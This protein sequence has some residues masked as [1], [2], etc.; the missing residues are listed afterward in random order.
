MCNW[1]PIK[2]GWLYGIA[3][4]HYSQDAPHRL[5]LTT[6]DAI[7]I[8]GETENWYFGYKKDDRHQQGIFPK[9]Y[10]VIVDAIRSSDGWKIRRSPIVEEITTILIEWQSHLLTY[11]LSDKQKFMKIQEKMLNLIKLRQQLLSGNLPTDEF[12]ELK[13]KATEQI[14]TGN[15]MLSLDMVVRDDAGNIIDFGLISTTQLY[16]LHCKAVERIKQS[17]TNGANGGTSTT[18]RNRSS[19]NYQSISH[20]FLVTL[21]SVQCKFVD[22]MEL[23][24]TLYA[25]ES[26][27]GNQTPQIYQLTE[28]YFVPW[29]KG[30]TYKDK[31]MLFTDLSTEDMNRSKIF[32]VAFMV[33]MGAMEARDPDAQ[34]PKG[35]KGLFEAPRRESSTS[36]QSLV[37]DQ[38]RRPFGVAILD[39]TPIKDNPHTFNDCAEMSIHTNEKEC[40]ESFLKR[41]LLNRDQLSSDGRS[42]SVSVEKVDGDI[43]QIKDDYSHI[44]R[45][46]TFARKMGFPEVIL[47]G[48]VRND[49]YL[50]LMG[51]DLG[52][53]LKSLWTDNNI[54]ICVSVCTDKGEIVPN[55]ISKGG[56]ASLENEYKSVIYTKDDRPKWNETIKIVLPIENFKHC[57]VK[58]LFKNRHS[59]EAKDKANK[60]FALAHVK[61]MDADETAIQQGEHSLAVY[62]ID[63]KADIGSMLHNYIDLPTENSQAN[64]LPEK[65]SAPGFAFMPKDSFIVKTNL[66]ST[67]LTQ[68]AQLLSLLNWQSNPSQLVHSLENL[69]QVQP[70]EMVKFYQ[71]ILDT[72]FNIFCEYPEHEKLVFKCIIRLIDIVSNPKYRLFESVLDVYIKEG[73]SATLAYRKLIDIVR[74]KI[75]ETVHYSEDA[76]DSQL[77]SVL[78]Y[79][80]Y[81]MK[82]TI[83]SRI[84]FMNVAQLNDQAEFDSLIEGLLLAFNQLISKQGKVLLK[85]KGAVLKY[86]HVVASDLIKV[87]DPI[88][89]R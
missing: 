67:R 29:M 25:M 72:L 60:P 43:K 65:P 58:F 33:R 10:V 83:Q 53:S 77:F 28:N 18:A 66:C 35:L 62:K 85:S 20:N 88:K 50:T 69:L 54:E 55:S 11:Y 52:K 71:D 38:L 13:L 49:L 70:S 76:T 30:D 3:K 4:S 75:F 45:N 87:Y 64:A 6:G 63:K 17:T 80:Q 21:N 8:K 74:L 81:I 31:K 89:L 23:L 26:K 51:A 46:L 22:D 84:L 48:D 79:L 14:D 82:F 37:I 32:L 86:L 44:E 16:E 68:D 56:G 9:S 5:T 1:Y 7:I 57:H 24:F 19:K 39:L 36:T 41:C 47:P 2:S 15:N 12:R 73:F 42:I 59:Q 40:L 34:P 78:K 61:L 27:E